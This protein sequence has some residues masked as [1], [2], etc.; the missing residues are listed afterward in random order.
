MT[1][2]TIHDTLWGG[3]FSEPTHRALAILSNSLVQDLP[4]ADADLR[5]SAVYA[6]ALGHAGIL[7]DAEATQL[8]AALESMQSDLASGHWVP[9][10]AEDIHTAIETELI[11]RVGLSGERLH[12]GRSRNDQVATAFRMVV[13]EQAAALIGGVRAVATTLLDRAERE[14]ETLLPAYTHLQR[15]QPVRLAHWLLAHFWPLIRDAERLAA[16]RDRALV[17]PLGSGAATG[18]PFELD[19]EW[20]AAEL[21]FRSVSPNSLDAVG[22]RDF[23]VELASSCTLL[24]VHLSRL[25]E[26]LVI[27][28]SAEFGFVHWPDSLATGSSLMPHKRNPD[29]AELVRGRAAAAIGDL[30][31]LLV[32]LKGLPAGYQRDL[33]DDKPPVWRITKTTEWSLTAMAAAID[34]IGFD[35]ERMRAALTDDL[36]ATEAAD[37][38]VA[39]GIPFRTAH[40]AVAEAVAAA[41]RARCGLR[42]LGR[43]PGAT[44]PSPLE[45]ADLRGLDFEAAVERRTTTGGT[46][47]QAVLDQLAQAK[48]VLEERAW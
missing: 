37:A 34:F 17:L 9:R 42:E 16:A 15:A 12:T 32:L 22:D 43:A 27:W 33:Q 40:R 30:T 24:A 2:T 18:N 41:R 36:L 13:G 47:R 14:V 4:L 45:P 29:L 35:R 26:E 28:S 7:S 38:M 5:A 21:G 6:R 46:A 10:D 8:S 25:A 31:A 44:L 1:Q 39:R 19:R 3:G 11:R 48:A 20:I 23:A